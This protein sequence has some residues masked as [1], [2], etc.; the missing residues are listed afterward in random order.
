FVV[1][2]NTGLILC[3]GTGG[4]RVPKEFCSR[5][6]K[7]N[8]GLPCKRCR[9]ESAW[10]CGNILVSLENSKRDSASAIQ[11]SLEESHV[12]LRSISSREATRNSVC[13][14]LMAGPRIDL[15]LIASTMPKLSQWISTRQP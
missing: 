3:T 11:L 10:S 13:R 15:E 9:R 2:V 6:R 8:I 14:I 1:A 4:K 7:A 12:A 5:A